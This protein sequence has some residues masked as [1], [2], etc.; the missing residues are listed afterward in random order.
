MIAIGML[1]I[2]MLAPSLEYKIPAKLITGVLLILV[3]A[4]VAVAGVLEFHLANTTVDP[5]DPKKSE[6]LVVTG[7][8]KT[9]RNPM[10]LGFVV[11]LLGWLVILANVASIL[12]LP[13]FVFYLHRFQIKPE[14]RFLSQKFGAEFDQ[15]C[16]SVRRWI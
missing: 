15:Y 1:V 3:G 16:S 13:V 10:Y 7:I 5:R 4:V 12:L 14:E 8:Y 11:I 2:S 6:V 9:S